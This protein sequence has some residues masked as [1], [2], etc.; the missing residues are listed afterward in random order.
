MPIR[1]IA[2]LLIQSEL[3]G[4]QMLMFRH[5]KDLYPYCPGCTYA[6][7][8]PQSKVLGCTMG[9]DPQVIEFSDEVTKDASVL[10]SE[11][12][13]GFSPKEQ[14][15][16][17]GFQDEAM[18]E[19]SLVKE[20]PSKPLPSTQEGWQALLKDLGDELRDDP[21]TAQE[22]ILLEQGLH[23]LNDDA[24]AA[25][26]GRPKDYDQYEYADTKDDPA[27]LATLFNE[28]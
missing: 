18:S 1:R 3:Q 14:S 26:D 12:C 22:G 25:F 11:K 20:I 6:A 5:G 13:P 7:Y 4:E 27:I 10:D 23:A 8:T 17:V 21:D 9:D 2:A 24:S 16:E 28:D 15:D 19:A